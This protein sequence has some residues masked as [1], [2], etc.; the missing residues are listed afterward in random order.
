M[1]MSK[2]QDLTVGQMIDLGSAGPITRAMLAFYAGGSNDHTKVHIDIDAA[3]EAGFEDVFVQGMF[4]MAL[5]GRLI[6]D[7]LDDPTQLRAFEARM[8]AKAHIGDV[9]ACEA[10]VTAADG[11]SAELALSFRNAAGEEK[12]RGQAS[13]AI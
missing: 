10:R 7:R 12:L 6:T 2:I 11:R 5:L 1:S 13:L 9:L 8:V 4:S 3:R